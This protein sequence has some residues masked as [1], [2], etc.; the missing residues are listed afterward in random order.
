MLFAADGEHTINQSHIIV[1]IISTLGGSIV[2]LLFKFLL[3]WRRASHQESI[4]ERREMFEEAKKLRQDLMEEIVSLRERI[5]KLQESNLKY[6][7]ENAELRS[8]LRD[9]REDLKKGSDGCSAKS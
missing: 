2:P 3:D 7:T 5:Y 9:L 4:N 1:A 8:T 6:A